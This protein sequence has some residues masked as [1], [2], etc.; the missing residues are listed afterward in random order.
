MRSSWVL[1]YQVL[2]R[3]HPRLV[4][5]L[6][7]GSLSASGAKI[8]KRPRTNPMTTFLMKL[9]GER[10]RTRIVIRASQLA[11]QPDLSGYKLNIANLNFSTCHQ[12]AR[13]VIVVR[14]RT[15]PDSDMAFILVYKL[16]VTSFVGL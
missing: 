8:K 14:V 10:F 9:D 4:H 11:W 1:T 2:L 3:S 15:F 13:A 12:S 5:P 6:H 16:G 7:H